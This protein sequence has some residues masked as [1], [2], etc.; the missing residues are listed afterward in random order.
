MI[1]EKESDAIQI[2][3]ANKI[4]KMVKRFEKDNAVFVMKIDYKADFD[5][6]KGTERSETEA[7]M[8]FFR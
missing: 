3:F 2:K 7:N 5:S 6:S 1:T 8:M 4:Y